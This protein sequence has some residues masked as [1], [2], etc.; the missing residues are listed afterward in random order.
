MGEGNEF[1]FS[2][3]VHTPK[4]IFTCRKILRHGASGFTSQPKKGVLRIFIVLK[5]PSPGLNL[6]T[7]GPM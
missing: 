3:L 5:R 4:A 1:G 2:V 6:R 7:L